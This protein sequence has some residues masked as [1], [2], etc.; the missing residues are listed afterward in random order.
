M[1]TAFA[2]IDLNKLQQAIDVEIKHQ[3]INLRGNQLYFSQYI[4]G[5]LKSVYKNSGK[6]PKWT[7]LTEA[8]EMYATESMPVRKRMIERLITTVRNELYQENKPSSEFLSSS[9]AKKFHPLPEV[10]GKDSDVV[11]VKGVGPKI[12]YL[13]NKLGIFTVMDLLQYY[14][15]KYVDYSKRTLIRELKNG[16][17]VTV[18]G[19]IKAC[20]AYM[21]KNSV[22]L[23]I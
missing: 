17:S 1:S 13:F 10:E 5:E 9:L 22:S 12:G 8:F 21:S 2:T 7:T 3:Y 16:E 11:Y 18:F 20:S 14:P 19:Y 23:G 6:N 4:L 15:K